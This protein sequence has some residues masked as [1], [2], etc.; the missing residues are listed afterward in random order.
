MTTSIPSAWKQKLDTRVYHLT[1]TEQEHKTL[2]AKN[3]SASFM[4]FADERGALRCSLNLQPWGEPIVEYG[5]Q[6]G[7]DTEANHQAILGALAE[8]IH[9]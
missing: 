1:L 2:L 6:V 5:F 3:K 8:Y 4:A 7:D 9:G